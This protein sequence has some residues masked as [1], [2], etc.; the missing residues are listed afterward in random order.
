MDDSEIA[1]VVPCDLSKGFDVV[2]N[3]DL[4]LNKLR[5]YNIDTTW[6]ESYLSERTA[7]RMA[8]WFVQNLCQ[9]PWACT[10]VQSSV[11]YSFWFSAMIWLYTPPG[12]TILQYAD[13]VQIAVEGKK[14]DLALLTASMENH[15][16]VLA[17]L[18]SSHGMKI[19]QV[20]TQLIVH[21]IKIT[22]KCST[23]SNHVWIFSH[24]WKSYRWKSCFDHGS[25]SHVWG[26]HQ[27]AIRKVYWTCDCT[28]SLQTQPVPLGPKLSHCS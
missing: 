11:R 15:P 12:A 22:A 23:G 13:D 16:A 26:S 4:L 17:D 2:V 28:V 8:S 18:F 3:R 10:R 21:G 7:E 27:S 25:A 24:W 20:K 14:S 6:F 1:L 9:S 5:L 19:N